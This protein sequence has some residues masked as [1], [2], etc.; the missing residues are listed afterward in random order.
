MD[1]HQLHL[2]QRRIEGDRLREAVASRFAKAFSCTVEEVEFLDLERTDYLEKCF[3]QEWDAIR[4]GS[5]EGFSRTYIYSETPNEVA[6]AIEALHQSLDDC[7]VALLHESS[8]FVGIVQS[9][10]HTVLTHAF[11]LFE[12]DGED[13]LMMDFGGRIGLTIEHFRD[14]TETSAKDVYRLYEWHVEA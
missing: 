1:E 12:Y 2:I 4:E 14:Y 6:D 10:L 3:R 11:D 8:E 9:T 7:A 5:I 13:L